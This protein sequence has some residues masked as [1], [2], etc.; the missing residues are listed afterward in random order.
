MTKFARI[1][2]ICL[3]LISISGV[4]LADGGETQGPGS[5]EPTPGETQGPGAPVSATGTSGTTLSSTAD[6]V[7]AG[8]EDLV[9]L[10][11]NAI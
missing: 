11:L 3:L 10:V 1:F 2:A 4:T 8:A 9:R 5:P 7:I 6:I